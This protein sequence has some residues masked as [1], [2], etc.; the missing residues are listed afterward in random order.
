MM[1]RDCQHFKDGQATDHFKEFMGTCEG[2]ESPHYRLYR[3]G[4]HRACPAYCERGDMAVVHEAGLRTARIAQ[5]VRPDPYQ[6]S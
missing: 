5:P 6:A 1:C 2:A 4:T 3:Y